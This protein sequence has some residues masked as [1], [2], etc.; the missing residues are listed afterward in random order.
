MRTRKRIGNKLLLVSTIFAISIPTVT[1]AEETTTH[2]KFSIAPGLNEMK[3]TDEL[4]TSFYPDLFMN[5]Y[6]NP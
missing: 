1:Y 4:K 2:T 3:N 5:S 6:N